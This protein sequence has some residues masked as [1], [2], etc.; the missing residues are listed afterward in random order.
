MQK[1]KRKEKKWLRRKW[2]RKMQYCSSG[3]G[4]GM[5]CVHSEYVQRKRMKD[6]DDGMEDWLWFGDKNL[7]S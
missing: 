6:E 5:G 7:R 4:G 1:M 2:K 3:G